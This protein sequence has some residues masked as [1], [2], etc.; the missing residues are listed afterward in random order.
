VP[1]F[2]EFC[3]VYLDQPVPEH[4]LR[5]L[6]L[7]EGRDPRNL[8]PAM[9]FRKGRHNL[10]LINYPPDHAKST[11]FSVNYPTYQIVKDPNTRGA[12]I[13]KT[14]NLARQF[15]GAVKNRLTNP[16]YSELQKAFAPEGGFEGESW[17]Q[18]AIFVGG[19]DSGEKDPTLQALGMGAA[20][21]GAR[22][23]WV[24]LDDCIDTSNAHR[25]EEQ[26]QWLSTEV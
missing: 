19:R 12:I 5:T 16:R 3:E 13:S 26:M 25:F 9:V 14:G 8:H 10:L 15:L 17:T 20:V 6:D 24:V 4:H 23:D 21:Y 7:M 2:P 11:C 22:L 1:D 18:S